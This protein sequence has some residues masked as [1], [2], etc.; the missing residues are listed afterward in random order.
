MT[1]RYNTF[2][3][4]DLSMPDFTPAFVAELLRY[5]MVFVALAGVLWLISVLSKKG[6]TADEVKSTS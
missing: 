1:D 4:Y 6:A 2:R 5:A 3:Q